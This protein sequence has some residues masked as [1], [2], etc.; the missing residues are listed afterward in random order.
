MSVVIRLHAI[1]ITDL[2]QRVKS[3]VPL[4]SVAAVNCLLQSQDLPAHQHLEVRVNGV[5]QHGVPEGDHQMVFSWQVMKAS[6]TIHITLFN[7]GVITK[8]W[9]GCWNEG[10]AILHTGTLALQVF[11]NGKPQP[12]AT[13]IEGL[14]AAA[15][16]TTMPPSLEA[17]KENGHHD[18]PSAPE[19][20]PESQSRIIVQDL[21]VIAE[22]QI[23]L[24][25]SQRNQEI[26]E[27]EPENQFGEDAREEIEETDKT[28]QEWDEETERE[29]EE[30]WGEEQD[31]DIG[32]TFEDKYAEE[33]EEETDREDPQ[34]LAQQ[35]TIVGVR[36]AAFHV[37][38]QQSEEAL[39]ALKNL[40]ATMPSKTVL[41]DLRRHPQTKK[42]HQELSGL[43][44]DHLRAIF[45]G[46]YWDRGWAIQ[47]TIRSVPTTES[48]SGWR[49]VVIHPESHPDEI[50]SLARFLQEGYCMIVMD[51][52]A[53]YAQSP[54]RGVIEEL[55]SRL[56]GL[57]VGPLG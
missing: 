47:T 49:R 13:T 17:E 15:T 20:Q 48:P 5:L 4:E 39:E 55:A 18:V 12:V 30:D 27:D 31:E 41:I 34:P 10:D 43:S 7:R 3:E 46:T 24:P 44:K 40:M 29:F 9:Q 45:G 11:F 28:D 16:L 50:A 21:F 57:I 38:V 2:P 14:T 54:R 23:A 19:A 35:D 26:Q 33:I 52:M 36:I 56:P 37:N 1:P 51:Q 32:A 53:T 6:D 42:K 8:H 25:E 22:P